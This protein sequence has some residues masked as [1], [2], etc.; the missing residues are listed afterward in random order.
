MQSRK[1]LAVLLLIFTLLFANQYSNA[2]HPD[3]RLYTLNC[4]TIDIHDGAS[5]SDTN[6]YSHASMTMADPC[7]LIKHDHEWLLWDLGLG[8]R[9]LGKPYQDKKY[10][11]TLKVDVTLQSQLQQLGLSPDNIHYILLSHTHFDH[12]GNATMFPHA[13]WLIQRDEYQAIQQRLLPIAV[14]PKLAAVLNQVHKKLLDSD[15]DIFGDGT[16][17]ILR[18]PGHTAGHQSL[19]LNLPETGTIILSGD[20]VHL[21]KAYQF[22]QVPVGNHNRADT[23]ASIARIEGILKNTHGRLIVQHDLKDYEALPK[24]PAYLK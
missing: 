24:P 17:I 12:M 4:G 5:F 19:Q 11:V 6:F 3:V 16:I 7:F 10:G 8:D 15:D 13:T 21:E 9:Y 23:L 14:E 22:K 2:V 18:T 1:Y 20:F